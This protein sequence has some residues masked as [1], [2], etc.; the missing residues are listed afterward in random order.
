MKPASPATPLFGSKP[1]IFGGNNNQVSTQKP[2]STAAPLFGGSNN[3]TTPPQKPAS[4]STPLFGGKSS[5]FG[6]NNQSQTQPL[7]SNIFGGNS[8]SWPPL[9]SQ[10]PKEN[11]FSVQNARLFSC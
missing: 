1:N 9:F 10:P 2:A 5:I 6:S 8:Q 11:M 7:K 3:N 4:P